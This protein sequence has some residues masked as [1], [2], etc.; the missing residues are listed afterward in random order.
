ME[1]NS[2]SMLSPFKGMLD[3]DTISPEEFEIVESILMKG[4]RE[5]IKKI[6]K[7]N[8]F[9]DKFKFLYCESDKRYKLRIPASLRNKY[10]LKPEYKQKRKS[11]MLFIMITTN[12]L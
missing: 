4:K 3:C 10:N 6:F 5:E 12:Y 9:E 7:D 11:L 1:N 2:N 8:G